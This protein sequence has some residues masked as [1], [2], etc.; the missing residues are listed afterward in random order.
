MSSERVHVAVSAPLSYA[1]GVSN[2]PDDLGNWFQPVSE[3]LMA[4]PVAGPVLRRIAQDDPDLIA[5]VADVDRSQVRDMLASSS[6]AWRTR[7]FPAI[8]LQA[9]S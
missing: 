2:E 7:I 8:A 1:R 9:P 5:A 6:N 3:A 4:A